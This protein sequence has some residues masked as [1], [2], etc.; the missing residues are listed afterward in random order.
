MCMPLDC[1]SIFFLQKRMLSYQKTRLG[2]TTSAVREARV[3][4]QS[5]ELNCEL[6]ENPQISRHYGIDGLKGGPQ[7]RPHDAGRR[8][9]LGVVFSVR[10]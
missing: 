5:W 8:S 7:L 6:S 9:S 10:F 3:S 4:R 1:T 2:K